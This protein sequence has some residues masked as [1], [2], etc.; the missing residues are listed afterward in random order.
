M[1]LILLQFKGYIVLKQPLLRKNVD[2]DQLFRI[3]LEGSGKW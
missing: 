1:N 3:S 2:Y